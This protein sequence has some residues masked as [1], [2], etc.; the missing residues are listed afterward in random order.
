M[1][2]TVRTTHGFRLVPPS[3]P[4]LWTDIPKE[5]PGT[6]RFTAIL[7]FSCRIGAQIPS[8]RKHPLKG[9]LETVSALFT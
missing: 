9:W 7:T 2:K 4:A 3:H 1:Q 8:A 6:F 5:T